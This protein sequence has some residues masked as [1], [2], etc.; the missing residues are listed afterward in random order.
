MSTVK[1]A[2]PYIRSDV[3]RERQELNDGSGTT[4]SPAK[5]NPCLVLKCMQLHTADSRQ[6]EIRFD[7][8]GNCV[9]NLNREKCHTSNKYSKIILKYGIYY[10]IIKYIFI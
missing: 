4:I 8:N 5:I 9:L 6:V 2:K 10:D 7:R 3:F 1:N